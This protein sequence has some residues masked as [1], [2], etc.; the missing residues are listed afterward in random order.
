VQVIGMPN[1][2]FQMRY[3]A[4]HKF[5]ACRQHFLFKGSLPQRV[6]VLD[7]RDRTDGVCAPTLVSTYGNS[8]RNYNQRSAWPTTIALQLLPHVNSHRQEVWARAR[9]RPN[10]AGAGLGCRPPAPVPPRL[11]GRVPRGYRRGRRNNAA[12]LRPDTRLGRTE[13]MGLVA[14]RA[15][16]ESIRGRFAITPVGHR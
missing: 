1:G 9:V 2:Q 14:R 10:H 15:S 11:I 12:K 13:R 5:L 4:Q 7:C 8:I 16:L 6:F 3:G